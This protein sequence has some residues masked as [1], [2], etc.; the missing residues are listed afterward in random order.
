M[1]RGTKKL[2]AKA[3]K[4]MMQAELDGIAAL[5]AWLDAKLGRGAYLSKCT[6]MHPS[7]ITRMR[8]GATR[9]TSEAAILIEINTN[10]ALRAEALCPS[11]ADPLRMYKG[12]LPLPGIV[13]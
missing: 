8:S 10:R 1:P 3:P 13:E 2:I 6:G 7:S 5:S 11:M 9:I 12:E 4:E